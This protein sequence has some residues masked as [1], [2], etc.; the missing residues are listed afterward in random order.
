MR[1]STRGDNANNDRKNPLSSIKYKPRRASRQ[2]SEAEIKVAADRAEARTML[3][4]TR[5]KDDPRIAKAK[6]RQSR[7]E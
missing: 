5:L 3:T 1:H 6:E 2:L 7:P 4:A